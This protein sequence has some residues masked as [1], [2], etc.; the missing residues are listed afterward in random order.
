MVINTPKT[1]TQTLHNFKGEK[2]ELKTWYEK[3]GRGIDDEKELDNFYISAPCGDCKH[4]GNDEPERDR[5][6]TCQIDQRIHKINDDCSAW[7]PK[8]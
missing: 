2:M 4:W 8:E 6:K 3:H 7:E 5:F 1:A